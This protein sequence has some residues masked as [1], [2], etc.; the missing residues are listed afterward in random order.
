MGREIVQEEERREVVH[1]GER[2][3]VHCI[4]PAASNLRLLCNETFHFKNKLRN[5]KQSQKQIRCRERSLCCGNLRASL[6]TETFYH[7]LLA[8]SETTWIGLKFYRCYSTLQGS[9]LENVHEIY[10]GFNTWF[11]C[12]S[13]E[14]SYLHRTIMASTSLHT[15]LITIYQD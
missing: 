2:R 14:E 3:D 6:C 9:S 12:G 1:E 10:K 7:L 4:I 11:V 8:V 5:A 15:K 13:L